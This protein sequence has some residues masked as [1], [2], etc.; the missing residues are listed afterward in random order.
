MVTERE[1][2]EIAEEIDLTL[3]N[4]QSVRKQIRKLNLVQ[5]KLMV[6]KR[7]LRREMR[8]SN[9]RD[10]EQMINNM[11]HAGMNFLPRSV[12]RW[13]GVARAG[14][15]EL[16]R[17]QRNSRSKPYEN[18]DDLIEDYLTEIANLKIEAQEYLN[19]I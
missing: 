6:I 13:Q 4:P 12:R 1:I 17:A 18:L 16:M 2:I 9:S 3:D 10:Q 7:E 8:D 19:E 11:M 15:R 5:Q 14:A